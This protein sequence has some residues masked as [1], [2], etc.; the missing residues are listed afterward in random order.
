MIT[1]DVNCPFVAVL[2]KFGLAH[3]EE[4]DRQAVFAVAADQE[5][6]KLLGV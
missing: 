4:A 6:R 1:E 2:A 5:A 3:T